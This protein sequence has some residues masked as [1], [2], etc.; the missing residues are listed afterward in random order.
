MAWT[1]RPRSDLRRRAKSVAPPIRGSTPIP[2]F[3]EALILTIGALFP[4]MNPFST[5]PL[6]V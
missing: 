2:I 1:V 3:A 4:I 6:Y 5:A